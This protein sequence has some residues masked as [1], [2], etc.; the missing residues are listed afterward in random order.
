MCVRSS[1]LARDGNLISKVVPSF[2]FGLDALDPSH[3]G[4][5]IMTAVLRTVL[6]EVWIPYLN[7]HYAV[8]GAFKD[9]IG[10]QQVLLR[11]G[12]KLTG[13]EKCLVDMSSKGR[14]ELQLA[15]FEWRADSKTA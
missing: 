9:N 2:L 4:R 12:F 1:L 13:Y 6:D 5:G 8:A 14:T 11:N 3:H 7:V 15:M 10:S